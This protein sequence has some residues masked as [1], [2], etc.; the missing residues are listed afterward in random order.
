MDESLRGDMS[1]ADTSTKLARELGLGAAMSIGIGTMICAGIFVLP[2]IAAAKAGPIVVLAFALCGIVAVLIAFC[3][4][5]LATGMPLDG[6]G[7]LFVERSFGPVLGSVMGGCLWLSLI[8]ASAFYMVGF[9]YYVAD[10]LSVPHVLL[11]LAMTGLLT[12]LNFIGAKETGSAQNV[13][14]A[15]LLIVLTVFFVRGVFSVDAENLRPL[16]PPE[17]GLSGFLVVTPI[18]FVTFMGFAEIAAVAEEI[19]NPHRNL[20]L[21]VIGSV[22]VV[23]VVYCLVEFCVVGL[24]R[25]DD[26]AMLSETVLM[27]IAH[28]LM[29]PTGYSL[30]LAGGICA[31]VSSANASIM[32]ASR[33]S[34]AMGRDGLMPDWFNQIHQ[35]FRTP[36][37]SILVTGVLTMI[38]LVI[39]GSHLELIAEVGAFLS[40]L[41]YAFISLS[42]M[43]MRHAGQ[44]WYKPSFKTP[45]YPLVPIL[46]LLGCV[47]VMIITSLP[48]I[49]I[50]LAIVAG[51]LVWYFLVLRGRTQLVGASRALWREKVVEPL[52]ARAEDYVASQHIPSS[53]ILLPLSNPETRGPLL[54]VGTALAKARGARLHLTH[55]LTVPVQTPLEAGRMEFEQRRLE[56]E[57][58][59]DLASRHAAE[60]GVRVRADTLVAHNVASAILSVADVERSDMI[61]LGWTGR[62][63]PMR[64]TNVSG[65]VKL[66]NHDV[67]VLKDSGQDVINRIL[68]PIGSGPHTKLALKVASFLAT[69]W[70]AA[71]TAMTVQVGQGISAARSETDQEDLQLFRNLAEE[72]TRD[73]LKEAGVTAEISVVVD[74]DVGNAILKASAENDLVVIGASNE[75]GVRQWLF[76]SLPD[77]V[78]ENASASVLIVRSKAQSPQPT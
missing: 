63:S 38:L 21:A 1:N 3:M 13:I 61:L 8:F 77:R 5:E 39:L 57:T 26:P 70:G 56:K 17:I 27:E 36:Y 28:M 75:W 53:V 60:E 59:L 31:T 48:T 45:A 4:S 72:F 23:T 34:F 58:V 73:S 52:V 6:G 16:I 46:G 68:V 15:A 19:K 25:Y 7:Y 44:S 50:G 67:L 20:P 35:R 37:R 40:L 76:G 55:V 65:I 30:I 54:T 41:L 11:A 12:G 14:V 49:L 66:A 71:V 22:I 62:H 78:A 64:S 74:P 43:V 29:G 10:V 33:I 47:F 2:G 32:A 42:C 69:Q 9:G 51:T 18:L 24:R